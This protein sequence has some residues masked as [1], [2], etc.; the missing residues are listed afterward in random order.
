MSLELPTEEWKAASA[1]FHP[2]P[3]KLVDPVET[4]IGK[5]G[6]DVAAEQILDNLEKNP[7]DR[8]VRRQAAL[9]AN[10]LDDLVSK[11]REK[12]SN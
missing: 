5:V 6:P 3:K 4:L 2:D 7:N 1:E 9:L 12:T 10:R 8:E 11:L